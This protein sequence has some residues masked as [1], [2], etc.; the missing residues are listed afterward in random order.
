LL[1]IDEVHLLNE[2]R[3]SCLEGIVSRSVMP[4]NLSTQPFAFIFVIP[5]GVVYSCKMIER[6]S[7]R[8]DKK[9]PTPIRFLALSA[10]VKNPEDVAKWY[11]FSSPLVTINNIHAC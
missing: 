7:D 4:I 1:L 5:S 3:G 2:N 6:Q 10:T 8:F 9:E 11:V